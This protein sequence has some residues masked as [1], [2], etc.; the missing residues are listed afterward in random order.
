[1]LIEAVDVNS[2]DFRGQT[3]LIVTAKTAQEE[4]VKLLLADERVDVA[5]RNNF[6]RTALTYAADEALHDHSIYFSSA[7]RSIS[8]MLEE[9]ESRR[10][11]SRGSGL[12][13]RF[14]DTLIDK[15]SVRAVR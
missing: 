11:G 8:R 15:L 13:G 6:S 1:M 12:V 9:A 14:K 10:S 3:P 7:Y 5:W 2:K 4:V